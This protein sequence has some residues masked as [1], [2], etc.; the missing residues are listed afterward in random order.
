MAVQV[1][2]DATPH[3]LLSIIK[4]GQMRGLCDVF[5]CLGLRSGGVRGRILAAAGVVVGRSISGLRITG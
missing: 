1:G 5:V 2:A 3:P 4:C